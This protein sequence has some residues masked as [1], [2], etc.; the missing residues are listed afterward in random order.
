MS[1]WPNVTIRADEGR[2]SV[3]SDTN[4]QDGT[5]IHMTGGMSETHVGARVTVG[6]NCILHGCVIEDDVLIGMGS[7]IMD[8]VRI[9][10]GSF[11][12]A[13]TLITPGK[14]IPP[15]SFVRGNPMQ[16]V[17]ECGDR[18]ETWI[19]YAAQHYVDNMNV[20]KEQDG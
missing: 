6:H 13:G 3:G 7:I 12:G 10:K 9:G 1:V 16:I 4:I 5:T 18:E 19:A 14:D 20:Y 8:N 17:R 15:G 11:I 2:I